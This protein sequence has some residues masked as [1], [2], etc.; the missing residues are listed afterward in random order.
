[1]H[2][3]RPAVIVDLRREVFDTGCRHVRSSISWGLV[4]PDIDTFICRRLLSLFLDQG[5]LGAWSLD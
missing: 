4:V 3:L 1:M 5:C 2:K